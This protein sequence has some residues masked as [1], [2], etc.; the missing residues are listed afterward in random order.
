M[1]PHFSDVINQQLLDNDDYTN[2][3]N[4]IN[5]L[6]MFHEDLILRRY[7]FQNWLK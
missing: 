4:V 3:T 2:N 7:Y 6:C 5:I 1:R